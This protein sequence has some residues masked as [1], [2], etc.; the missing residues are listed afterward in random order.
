MAKSKLPAKQEMFVQ[1]YLKDLNA[2]AAYKRS[3]PNCKSATAA[4]VESTRLLASPSI[5]ARVDAYRSR[6]EKNTNVSQERVLK[7]LATVAF[8]SIGLMCDWDADND[9]TLKPK[10]ELTP[11]DMAAIQSIQSN[12]QFYQ[13]ERIGRRINFKMHDK[14]KALELLCKHLGILDGTGAG[15]TG[16]RVDVTQRLRKSLRA[17]MGE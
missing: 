12:D 15:N 16:D 2:T 7:E 8:A 17:F 14:L 10:T 5:R 4:R 13:N 3:Y 1:E 6:A 11:E 9:L